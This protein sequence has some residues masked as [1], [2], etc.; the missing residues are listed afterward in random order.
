M[1][2]RATKHPYYLEVGEEILED[3]N[4]LMRVECGFASLSDVVK[5]TR[6]DRM[7]SFF[8][9]ETLK[10]LYLLFDEDNVFNHL[11]SNFVFSTGTLTIVLC[12]D[13]NCHTVN[14]LN[15]KLQLQSHRGSYSRFA[16]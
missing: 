12:V 5:K 11:D 9:S 10:Y 15:D 3:L 2:Y 16:Q 6:T 7:E 13:G 8:L 14:V 1:L 4:S